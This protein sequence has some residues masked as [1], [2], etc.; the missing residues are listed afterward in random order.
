MR[1]LI[2]F[3]YVFGFLIIFNDSTAMGQGGGQRGGQRGG[4]GMRGGQTPPLLRVFDADG[5]GE[6]STEEINGAVQKLEK[7]DRNSDG[8]LTAEELRPQG[9]GQGGPRG[10]GRQQRDGMQRGRNGQQQGGGRRGQSGGGRPG[11]NGGGRGGDPAQ[12]DALFVQQI[13]E[14]D[15]NKDNAISRDEL[16]E[17]MHEALDA[18]DSDKDGKANGKE[19]QV[20]A[21][22]FR[23]NKLNPAGESDQI[24]NRPTQGGQRR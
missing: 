7:L 2:A 4:Q 24:K 11:G 3:V 14:L 12:A 1:N 21:S 13:M 17:H 10:G 16:P 22:H 8:R 5:D 18:S 15:Q 6:L 20:L 19:L 9:R 23:R